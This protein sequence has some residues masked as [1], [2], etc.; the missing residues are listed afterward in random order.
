VSVEKVKPKEL[1][2]LYRAFR[3]RFVAEITL[4]VL[5]VNGLRRERR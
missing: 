1:C 2:H 5:Y 4:L 3:Q